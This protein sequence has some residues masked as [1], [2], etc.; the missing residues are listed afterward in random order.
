M[1]YLP[2]HDEAAWRVLRSTLGC[3]TWA[4]MLPLAGVDNVRSYQVSVT[5]VA[6]TGSES[7]VVKM[8]GHVSRILSHCAFEYFLFAQ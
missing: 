5:S 3:Y 4:A 1:F 2:N 6:A 7:V 8:E